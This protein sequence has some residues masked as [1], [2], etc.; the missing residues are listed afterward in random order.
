[1]HLAPLIISEAT[2]LSSPSPF[3]LQNPILL[4]GI[5]EQ[6]PYVSV[7][8]FLQPKDTSPAGSPCSV[9]SYGGSSPSPRPAE[10]MNPQNSFSLPAPNLQGL[11]GKGE[12]NCLSTTLCSSGGPSGTPKQGTQ[13]E[14]LTKDI[15]K[16]EEWFLPDV[17]AKYSHCIYSTG[18]KC[19][20]Y[21]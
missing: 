9:C 6:N 5:E 17:S 3:S 18:Q 12:K 19:V 8:H 16:T 2:F 13:R 4:L 1:M 10:G 11:T 21:S 15:E 20:F 14:K 7:P